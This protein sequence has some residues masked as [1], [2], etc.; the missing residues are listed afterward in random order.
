ME[1]PAE[2]KILKTFLYKEKQKFNEIE[3]SLNMRSN[4]LSYHLTQLVKKGIL[5]K[6]KENYKLSETSEH[7]IPYLS[8][9]NSVLTVLLIAVTKNNKVFLHKRNKRP[10]QNKLGLPGGRIL[11]K[12][13]I[14]S[15]TKRIL[16]EKHNI[17]AKLGKVH[18]V[19]VESIKKSGKIIQTDLIIFVSAST[20]DK[21]NYTSLKSNK[22]KII[23]SDYQLLEKD[24][25]KEIKINKFVTKG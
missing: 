17:N 21:I 9:K 3:K 11:L 20:K 2:Y 24:L 16:K 5:L 8:K 1:K 15:A 12:E 6:Q 23:S 18:S 10:F 13:N 25:D 19:S 7:L 22:S 4:K 14:N